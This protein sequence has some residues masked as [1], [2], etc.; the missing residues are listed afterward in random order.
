MVEQLKLRWPEDWTKLHVYFVP[1]PAEIK[2]LVDA[3]AAVLDSLDCVAR[4]PVEWLH[5]TMMVLDGVPASDVPADQ[6]AELIDRLKQAVSD[7]P[8][9]TVTCGPAVA[10]RGTVTLDMVPDKDFVTLVGRVKAAA[11]QMFGPEAV[12]YANN[13]PHITLAYATG[14]GDSGIIQDKL[15][16]ATDLRATLTVDTVR[17]VDVLVDRELF[18][19]RWEELAVLPLK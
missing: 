17:L 11:G 8:S 14:D 10:G 13:R 1:D 4:Q 15:R 3:Y 16:H 12:K 7:V 19:F 18:Q 6:R 5:S 2:P 9:F